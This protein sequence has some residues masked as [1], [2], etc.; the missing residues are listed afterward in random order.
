MEHKIEMMRTMYSHEN[1]HVN[2]EA[3]RKS[4]DFIDEKRKQAL[5]RMSQYRQS[6]AR[7]YNKNLLPRNFDI[8]DLV[9]IK[10]F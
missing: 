8:G 3:L 9:L 2:N 7:Y 6:I 5:I 4:L 10:V 1:E